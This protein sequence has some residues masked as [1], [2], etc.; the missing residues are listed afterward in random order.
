MPQTN[1]LIQIRS[2]G[3]FRFIKRTKSLF[4]NDKIT[5]SQ[6]PTSQPSV[7]EIE[8]SAANEVKDYPGIRCHITSLPY[9][10]K[11]YGWSGYYSGMMDSI[12]K[13]PD[14]EGLL[15]N[16]DGRILYGEWR[17]GVWRLGMELPMRTIDSIG[18]RRR[19][20]ENELSELNSSM[21]NVKVGMILTCCDVST[22]SSLSASV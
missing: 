2:R 12:A 4:T 13:L 9:T 15:Y 3:R 11:T 20:G 14:G 19:C 10:D 16:N 5:T 1:P 18:S 7:S 8:T 17:L 22:C 6:S 21:E